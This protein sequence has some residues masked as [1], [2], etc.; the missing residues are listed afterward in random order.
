LNTDCLK[1]LITDNICTVES[2]F[3]NSRAIENVSNCIFVSNNYLP[4]KIENG[5]RRYVI[6]KT[7]NSWKIIFNTLMDWIWHL[8]KSSIMHYIIFFMSRVINDFKARIIPITDIKNDKIE[9]CKES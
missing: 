9:S 1:S 7:C 8:H 2:K 4:I 6:F 5:D 3:V